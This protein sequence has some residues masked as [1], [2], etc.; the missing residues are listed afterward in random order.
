MADIDI[1]P[2]RF[3]GALSDILSRVG[4]ATD[5][6]VGDAVREGTRVTARKW[7]ANARSALGGTG[8]YAASISYRVRQA[9]HESTGEVG[10]AKLPGLPHLLEKGHAKV[11]GGRVEGRE[12]IASAAEEGF[13]AT[14]RAVDAGM[15]AL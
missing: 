14:N 12:H 1:V 8:R 15:A 2:D 3:A 9:G 13:D 6:V 5:K 4:M 10:S 7:R 11:G